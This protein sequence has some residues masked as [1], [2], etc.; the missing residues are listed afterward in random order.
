MT[1]F[2]KNSESDDT[3]RIRT[4]TGNSVTL[5]S[6]LILILDTNWYNMVAI[7]VFYDRQVCSY[8]VDSGRNNSPYLSFFY[9]P[10]LL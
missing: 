6:F 3:K 4:E 5:F 2:G 8:Y 9:E 7:Y 10:C 1:S